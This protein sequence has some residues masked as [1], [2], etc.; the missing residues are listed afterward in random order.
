MLHLEGILITTEKRKYTQLKKDDNYV[1]I[2]DVEDGDNN[3]GDN[4][5]AMTHFLIIT[6]TF[7]FLFFVS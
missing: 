5:D 2:F 7:C 6:V 3:D 1:V 4:N